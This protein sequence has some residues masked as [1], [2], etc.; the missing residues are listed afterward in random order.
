[1]EWMPQ[2]KVSKADFLALSE[3]AGEMS[4]IDYVSKIIHEHVAA[5]Q[6]AGQVCGCPLGVVHFG[7]GKAPC[8]L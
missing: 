4:I 7:D 5:Q 2:Y 6:S 1:M 3:L 8:G